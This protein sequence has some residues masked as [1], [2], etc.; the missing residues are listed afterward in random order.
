MSRLVLVALVSGS[1]DRPSE[2]PFTSRGPPCL[3]TTAAASRADSGFG[4]SEA[5]GFGCVGVAAAVGGGV[6]GALVAECFL[7]ALPQP[8][9][10][11]S[12]N[13]AGAAGSL[14]HISIPGCQ[15]K[16]W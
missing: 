8:A 14:V 2:R 11:S 4:H 9:S 16:R 7:P 6:V 3:R 13:S 1:Q 15:S 10:A 12:A 5:V